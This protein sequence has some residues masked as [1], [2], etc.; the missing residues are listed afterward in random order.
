[1]KEVPRA[2]RSRGLR[3]ILPNP[4]EPGFARPDAA[5]PADTPPVSSPAKLT[6]ALWERYQA[7]QPALTI[8][9]CELMENNGRIL[10]DLVTGLA[11]RWGLPADFQAW[12]REECLW[13]ISLVDRIVVA[14]TRD[15]PLFDQDPMLLVTEPYALWA[16]ERPRPGWRAP[17]EHPSVQVVDDLTPFYL[18]KVRILN[19]IHT[20]LVA[21]YLP[22]G[23]TTVQEAMKDPEVVDWV[24]GLLYE[25]I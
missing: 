15:H 4:P 18:R 20:A 6:R 19:G 25:E 9:A 5:R 22:R 10:R 24:L 3:W 11:A 23:F 17:V 1:W 12:L 2:A 14:P 16:I 21:R 8:L 13:P 7:R